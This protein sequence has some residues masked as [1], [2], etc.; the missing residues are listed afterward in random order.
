MENER[1][2][3]TMKCLEEVRRRL[4]KAKSTAEENYKVNE[5]SSYD[6]G[7]YDGLKQAIE[8]VDCVMIDEAMAVGFWRV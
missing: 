3:P 4:Q 6:A 1:K 8:V 7:V 2:T 5:K